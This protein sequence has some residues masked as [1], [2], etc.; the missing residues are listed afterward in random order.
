MTYG[1]YHWRDG[2][3]FQR[4]QVS[5]GEVQ[6]EIP[7]LDDP[8]KV[9]TLFIPPAEWA[10]IVAAVCCEGENAERY[11]EALALHMKPIE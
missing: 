5:E 9:Q 7:D 8:N 1:K 6:I 10:S 11:R 2:V 3:C 4:S